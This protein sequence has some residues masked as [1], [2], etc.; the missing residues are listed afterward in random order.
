MR[1]VEHAGP[2]VEARRVPR[3]AELGFR[4]TWQ[5]AFAWS[6]GFALAAVGAFVTFTSMRMTARRLLP[7]PFYDQ[8]FDVL[9]E[10]SLAT[11]FSQHNEHRIFF[12]RLVFALDSWLAHGRGT[13]SAGTTFA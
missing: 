13:F 7:F 1:V 2:V 4:S 8:W 11:P 6:L 5:S 12:G 10:R 9:P 3:H